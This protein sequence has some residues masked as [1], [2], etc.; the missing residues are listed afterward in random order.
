MVNN[1]NPV[2]LGLWKGNIDVQPCGS[3]TAVAYYVAKYASKCEPHDTGDV[4][5]DATS[6]AKRKGGDVWKQLFS[7]SMTILSQRLVS[8]PEY[9][10]RLCHLPLK[11]SLQKT[12]FV[13]SCR[14]EERFR[15]LNLTV[16]KSVFIITFLIVMYY[17]QPS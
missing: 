15:L 5:R 2:L 14:P 3:V 4:I 9:A 10:Y 13:N 7:V 6:N 12:I 11:M 17:A 8:A 1:Y 16:M